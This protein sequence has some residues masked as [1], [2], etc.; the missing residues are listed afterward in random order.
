M[1][2]CDLLTLHMPEA[3]M[4]RFLVLVALVLLISTGLMLD[5]SLA[6]KARG[7]TGY[8]VPDYVDD[9]IAVLRDAL[10]LPQAG[11]AAAA[12]GPE[13]G[14]S[15]PQRTVQSRVS[16]AERPFPLNAVSA[17]FTVMRAAS[18]DDLNMA[19]GDMATQEG[20]DGSANALMPSE[21]V[22]A[23][24][25]DADSAPGGL[26]KTVG[27]LTDRTCAT[28]AGTKFCAVGGN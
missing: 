16:G 7:A 28:K 9:R 15:E 6:A 14:A 23:V 12:A 20:A 11:P 5:Y 13:A 25:G 4:V 2:D 17:V 26:H 19:S 3:N 10:P 18:G 22:M 21:D 27:R 1:P 24:K 8:S